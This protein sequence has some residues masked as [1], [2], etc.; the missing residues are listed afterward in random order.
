MNFSQQ[1][2]VKKFSNLNFAH[3]ANVEIGSEDLHTTQ[4]IRLI[5]ESYC[6]IRLFAYAKSLTLQLLN[7]K[8]TVRQKLSKI[9]L[10]NHT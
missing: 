2:I 8:S 1:E 4:I 9:I 10:F 6:K 5:A 7:N 3:S